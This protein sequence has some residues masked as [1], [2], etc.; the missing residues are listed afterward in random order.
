MRVLTF[1]I[2]ER[3]Q[4][5]VL[6]SIDKKYI[7][8]SLYSDEKFGVRTVSRMRKASAGRGEDEGTRSPA[9][10]LLSFTICVSPPSPLANSVLSGQPDI[11]QM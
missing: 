8:F 1:G 3:R 6:L 4:N 9:G 10:I 5:I 7:V 11:T 2:E